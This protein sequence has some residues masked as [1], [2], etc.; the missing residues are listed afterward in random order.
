L[1]KESPVLQH[2]AL[3]GADGAPFPKVLKRVVFCINT[4]AFPSLSVHG[5][6][7]GRLPPTAADTEL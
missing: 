4:C 2:L 6:V 3:G 1:Q 7:A 5:L